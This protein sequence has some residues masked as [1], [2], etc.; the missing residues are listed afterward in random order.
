MMTTGIAPPKEHLELGDRVRF[1]HRACVARVRARDHGNP[2][3]WLGDDKDLFK[4]CWEVVVKEGQG[5]PHD[6]GE[7]FVEKLRVS[8]LNKTIIIWPS[9]G[10]GIVI[11]MIRRGIGR[12]YAGYTSGYEYPE[13]EPGYFVAEEWHWLYLVKS[14]LQQKDPFYVPLWAA[15][16]R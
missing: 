5:P 9:E 11:G 16:K 3:H 2:D 13:Y 6:F 7:T 10:E 8:K 12:S 1:H 14:Y 15:V 4:P